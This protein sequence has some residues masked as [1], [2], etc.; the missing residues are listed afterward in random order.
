M[1]APNLSRLIARS[2]GVPTY[3]LNLSTLTPQQIVYNGKCTYVTLNGGFSQHSGWCHLLLLR[4]ESQWLAVI[5]QT[6]DCQISIV[7]T[8]EHI[9][10]F[11]LFFFNI[12]LMLYVHSPLDEEGEEVWEKLDFTPENTTF[13]QYLPAGC[14]SLPASHPQHEY[15]VMRFSWEEQQIAGRRYFQAGKP[16]D[17]PYVMGMWQHVKKEDID[18]LIQNL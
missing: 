6:P 12:P 16:A 8:I 10:S 17:E 7:N 11:V 4:G 9:A 18:D 15:A 14:F 5:T 3:A 2:I 1:A 13:V